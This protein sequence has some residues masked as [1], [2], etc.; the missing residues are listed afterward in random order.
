MAN[1]LE[2]L[3]LHNGETLEGELQFFWGGHWF[4]ANAEKVANEIIENWKIKEWD[5]IK[6]IP[7]EEFVEYARL[8]PESELH[9]C[10]TWDDTEAA[11]KW[12]VHEAR[13]LDGS[14]KYR[15][16][17]QDE[18]AEEVPAFRFLMKADSEKGYIPTAFIFKN[19]ELNAG[20]DYRIKQEIH[21]FLKKY[22][23]YVFENPEITQKVREL[24]RLLLA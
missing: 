2:A 24:D 20:K 21:A 16:V 14:L 12:R 3:N 19:E 7:A 11:E 17:H 10:F 9:K 15:F 8:N 4:K 6:H 1:V 23:T 13:Q 22:L 18:E 5:E